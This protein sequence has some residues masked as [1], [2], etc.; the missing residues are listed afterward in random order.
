MSTSV[1]STPSVLVVGSGASARV[2]GDRLRFLSAGP[3]DH[4]SYFGAL[5]PPCVGHLGWLQLCF[6]VACGL[7]RIGGFFWC[8]GLPGHRGHL[9]DFHIIDWVLRDFLSFRGF[10]PIFFNMV[11]VVTFTLVVG[12]TGQGVFP[13]LECV[14][15]CHGFIISYM[16]GASGS[17]CCVIA[18]K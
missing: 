18:R 12:V 10:G 5:W 13:V 4:F 2:G 17:N 3:V 11:C 14:Q 6:G 1:W 7:W 8:L 16:L 9:E 15:L